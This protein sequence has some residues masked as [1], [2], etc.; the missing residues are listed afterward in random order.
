M[1]YKVNPSDQL[2]PSISK[3]PNKVQVYP[4]QSNKK[5]T[6]NYSLANQAFFLSKHIN[7]NLS[8]IWILKL[9]HYF[10]VSIIINLLNPFKE[11]HTI[12]EGEI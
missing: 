7:K 1:S 10:H 8:P 11:T 9:F 6:N 5:T 12:S 2:N 4:I 3:Q